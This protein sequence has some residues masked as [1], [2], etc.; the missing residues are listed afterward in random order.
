MIQIFVK[1]NI[2]NFLSLKIMGTS[3]NKR[4]VKMKKRRLFLFWIIVVLI[5]PIQKLGAQDHT[6]QYGKVDFAISCNEEAQRTFTQGIALLHHMMYDQAEA[7]FVNAAEADPGCAMAQWGIA[8][9]VIHPLWGE[10]PTDDA[11]EKGEQAILK[12]Q[13]LNTGTER[14]TAYLE[15]VE[16]FYK[17]WKNTS[18]SDQLLAFE[19]GYRSLYESFPEDTDAAAFYALGHLATA[20]KADKTYAHQKKA[21]A[22]LEELHTRAPEHPG[23]FHYIIH[24]YDNPELADRALEVAR[25]YDKVAPEVPHAL[26]MPSHIFVREGIWPDVINWNQR[27]AKAALEQPV[28]NLTSMHYPHAMDYLMYAYLQRGEDQKAKEVLE[29]LNEVNNFQPGLASAYAIAAVQA[30]YPLERA[31]WDEGAA[32]SP[33]IDTFTIEQYPA[34]QS[35]LY[36]GRGLSAARSGDLENARETIEMLDDIHTKL[37][38]IN[39]QYWAVL[40]DAQRS[41]IAA[42]TA[43]ATDDK[44]RALTLMKEAADTEDSVDKHPVTP[45]H[46]LPARELLGEMLLLL[47]K[48][49]EALQ[50]YEMSLE[51]SAN[52]FNS[53]YGAGKAAEKAGDIEKAKTYYS[54]LVEISAKEQ[55]ER[56]AVSEAKNFLASN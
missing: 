5:M 27:S 37:T 38:E 47:D 10:R 3:I 16:G 40:T 26:H 36:Y 33:D 18:Y 12:A 11:F 54:K 8:M 7:K 49:Q 20:P 53:L 1:F 28:G 2:I 22:L 30:R 24:A 46:V 15:A 56:P 9:T 45:G 21:G 35:I 25:S 34:A 55:V 13:N 31:E 42:W 6:H 51:I 50:A 19:E 17:D 41:S 52:R 29:L 23:L 48:P 14:E 4:R 43:F 39:E 32:I 44:E